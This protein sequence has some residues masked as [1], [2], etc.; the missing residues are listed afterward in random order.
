MYANRVGIEIAMARPLE[1]S[2]LYSPAT[3]THAAVDLTQE[4]L[5]LT[6][7]KR[8]I[9]AHV[10]FAMIGKY[11]ERD[12]HYYMRMVTDEQLKSCYLGEMSYKA[13]KKNGDRDL[14]TSVSYN[15]LADFIGP[16]LHLVIVE[17]GTLGYPNKAM[18]GIL[19]EAM[20]IRQAANK[21]TWIFDTPENPWKP[22]HLSY[23]EDV[24]E[25]VS[26]YKSIDLTSLKPGQVVI[27]RNPT[28]T[29]YLS[30]DGMS[31]DK[32][33]VDENMD[34]RETVRPR[35]ASK[36]MSYQEKNSYIKDNDLDMVSE[37]TYGK[38]NRKG[39]GWK[40]GKGGNPV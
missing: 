13:K 5:Y 30:E 3:Q 38:K 25:Y 39:G 15:T 14:D 31:I 27:P 24:C 21:P 35:S 28:T 11:L 22:G 16:D 32:D 10:R 29:P 40:G 33:D 23:N 20:L 8:D 26:R 12:L 9:L 4:N 6:G 34:E 37:D 36:P 18:P 7:W 19:K 1:S 2:P 17:L